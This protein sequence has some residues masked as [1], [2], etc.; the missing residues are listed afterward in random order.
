MGKGDKKTKRGKI[1][2][3]S[4]GVRRPKKK[5]TTYKPTAKA[6]IKKTETVA[7]PVKDTTEKKVAPKKAAPKKAVPAVKQESKAKKPAAKAAEKKATPAVKEK[8][9]SAKD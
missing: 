3:G 6:V 2:A 4:Y 5:K 7:K 9:K 8:K 1:V